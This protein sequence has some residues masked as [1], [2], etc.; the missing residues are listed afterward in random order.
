MPPDSA[1]ERDM[2][3]AKL[4]RLG[5]GSASIFAALAA[6][7]VY[8]TTQA[9]S[10]LAA[11]AVLGLFLTVLSAIDIET[12]RLPN[13]LTYTLGALGLAQGWLMAPDD[14]L[15]RLIGLAAGFAMLALLAAAY[16]RS[17]GKDGLGLGDAKLLGAGGAWIGALGLPS[18]LLMA[19][20]LAL[21]LALAA[22]AAGRD[23]GPETR[24]PFGP[25]I[26]IGLWIVWLYGPI[27]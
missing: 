3:R 13:P 22:K 15:L 12:Q 2:S 19:S 7:A 6:P 4:T 27:V 24:I 14:V 16:R 23:I 18:A 9:P 8:A 5:L 1:P 26:A 20:S 10:A 17:R 25:F 21:V 11:T